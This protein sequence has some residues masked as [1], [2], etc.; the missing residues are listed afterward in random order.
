MKADDMKRRRRIVLTGAWGGGKSA[1]LR[2]LRADPLRNSKLLILPE[3]GPLARHVG[4]HPEAPCYED[5]V[6]AIQNAVE[7]A[8]ETRESEFDQRV[9]ISHRGSLDALAF[10]CYQGRLPGAF[11]DRIRSDH[12]TELRRYDGVLFFRSTAQGA[13]QVYECYRSEQGRPTADEAL[14]LEKFLEEVWMPHPVC[15]IVENEGITWTEKL[16][17]A[18]AILDELLA[19]K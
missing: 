17:Q 7:D 4:F 2:E 9:V 19:E 10:W 18:R 16:A 14:R 3:S 6:V 11:F 8:A 5:V 15:R 12:A 13:P 1:F